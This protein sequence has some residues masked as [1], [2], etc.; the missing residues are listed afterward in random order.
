MNNIINKSFQIIFAIKKIK[1]AVIV[2]TSDG[3]FT[4]RVIARYLKNIPFVV[5]QIALITASGSKYEQK[6]KKLEKNN[7]KTF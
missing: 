3:T 5:L 6:P 1:P 7:F 2:M 4:S